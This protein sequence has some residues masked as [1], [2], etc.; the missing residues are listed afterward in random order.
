MLIFKYKINLLINNIQLD[1]GRKT[2]IR[3]PSPD[4]FSNF[5]TIYRSK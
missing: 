1:L 5:L 2:L 4:R 3:L